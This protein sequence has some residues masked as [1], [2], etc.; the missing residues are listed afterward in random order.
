M[1]NLQLEMRSGGEQSVHRKGRSGALLRFS[2]FFPVICGDEGFKVPGW[3]EV[4]V[5]PL[6]NPLGAGDSSPHGDTNAYDP[7][8]VWKADC[9]GKTANLDNH[10]LNS[11]R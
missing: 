10:L 1:A 5:E 4:E 3:R 11:Y 8:A 9:A 2:L 7:Q 6:Q